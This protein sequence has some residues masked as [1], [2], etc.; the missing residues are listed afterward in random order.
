[1]KLQLDREDVI[2]RVYDRGGHV[3]L[4]G[5]GASIAATLR[6][7]EKGGKR[8]P[9]MLNL[10]ELVGLQDVVED[11]R[12]ELRSDNFEELYSNLHSDNPDSDAI[13]EI[14]ARIHAF[15]AGMELPDA[16]TIYDYLICSLRPKDLIATFNW[17]PFLYQAWCRNKHFDRPHVSF[18]HGNVAIGYSK[19]DKR[20]GPAGMYFKQ[21]GSYAEPTKLLYPVAQKDYN[22]DEFIA[23]EWARLS[24]WL[25][26]DQTKRVTVFGYSAPKTDFEA[27]ALLRKAWGTIDDRNMEQ[28]EFINTTPEEVL[29]K[30]WKAFVHTH[31]YDYTND[32][33]ASALARY[34]RRTVES[35]FHHYLPESPAEAFSEANPVPKSFG[36]LDEMWSWFAP[37]AEAE[38]FVT[39]LNPHR[40]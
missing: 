24:A 26:D 29:L 2:S 3:V 27:M 8:L 18:L 9:S 14:E 36:T 19:E 1:M 22:Q 6:N 35:Y 7:P 39:R 28:L 4:L 31:H 30:Q 10:V 33:F 37:L 38:K 11:V 25:H 15:F 13:H 21:T 17:D 12:S 32:F 40:N 34:P 16:P 5:A 23:I 20:C